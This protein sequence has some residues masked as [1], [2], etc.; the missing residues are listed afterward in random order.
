MGVLFVQLTYLLSA[1]LEGKGENMLLQ[2]E[3]YE[4]LLF[5]IL[6][7]KNVHN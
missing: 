6:S 1:R 2:Q 3:D 4:S 7:E 5:L